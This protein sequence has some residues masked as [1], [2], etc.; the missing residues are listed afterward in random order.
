MTG[1]GVRRSRRLLA[2]GYQGFENIGDEAIL[3]GIEVVLANGPATVGAIV[4]GP[5]PA[6]VVGFPSAR[7]ISSARLLPT[8]RALRALW[9]SDGLLLAGGG[10]IHDHWPTVIPRYL[11]WIA[12][13]RAL[14][15]RVIWL[16]VGVGPIHCASLRWLARISRQLSTLALV[17]DPASAELLGGVGLRVGITPDPAFFNHRPPRRVVSDQDGELA[18]IIRG[19]TPRDKHGADALAAALIDVCTMGP[20][21]GWHPVLLTMAGPADA[22]FAERLRRRARDHGMA[23]EIASLATTPA[24]ALER[25]AACRAVISVRL[26]GLVLAALAGVPCVPVAYDA[27]VRA[28]AVQLGIGDLVVAL[29]DVTAER[30]FS[31]LGDAIA[32]GRREDVAVRL[33]RMRDQQSLVADRLANAAGAT[34]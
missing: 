12:L 24:D 30:L 17:R 34:W 3:S 8:P 11:A 10:L 29:E 13:A 7:R 9:A 1:G 22:P 15:K 31:R 14:G 23:F 27:K 19:P 25:L 21:R 33:D 32:P 18:I 2:I 28:A 4:C 16:G 26:H 20:R 5:K 6:S